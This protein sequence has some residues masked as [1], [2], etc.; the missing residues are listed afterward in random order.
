MR[1]GRRAAVTAAVPEGTAPTR[2]RHRPCSST[3][4]PLRQKTAGALP[5]MEPYGGKTALKRHFSGRRASLCRDV[6]AT[7]FRS[8]PAVAS[9]KENSATINCNAHLPARAPGI[10]HR[11]PLLPSSPLNSPQLPPDTMSKTRPPH[12]F[13]GPLPVAYGP[14]YALHT[15]LETVTKSRLVAEMIMAGEAGDVHLFPPQPATAAEL[16]SIHDARYV[17]SILA[18]R[19]SSATTPESLWR[20][21]ASVRS[22]AGTRA[23]TI[24]TG[25]LWWRKLTITCRRCHIRSASSKDATCSSTTRAWI[26]M[27]MPADSPALPPI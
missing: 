8:V 5:P 23:T 21:S 22:T 6:V 1:P 7:G 25:S 11:P 13:Q 20:T 18:L 2:D 9:W 16:R 4:P 12:P 3:P 10:V 15:G 19:T 14:D 26:L 27:S 17:D 24:V